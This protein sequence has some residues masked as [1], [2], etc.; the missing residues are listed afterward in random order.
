MIA[1]SLVPQFAPRGSLGNSASTQQTL[2]LSLANLPCHCC[3]SICRLFVFILLRIP[4]LATPFI[5][6]PYKTPG[7]VGRPLFNFPL[8]YA[9]YN[10]SSLECALTQNAPASP[11]ESALTENWVGGVVALDTHSTQ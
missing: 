1:A 11:L 4:F 3:V 2:S 5:S 6:H 7:G 10:V 8:P 9:Y